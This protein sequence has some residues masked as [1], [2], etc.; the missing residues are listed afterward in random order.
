[1]GVDKFIVKI[2]SQ[3]GTLMDEIFIFRDLGVYEVEMVYFTDDGVK[4]ERVR[5]DVASPAKPTLILPSP[6]ARGLLAGF[7]ELADSQGIE[8]TSES[9]AIGKLEAQGRHLEDLRT[10]LKLK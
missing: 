8:R 1:M 2:R 6:I 10:L 9:K 5:T 3:I 7:A 4:L